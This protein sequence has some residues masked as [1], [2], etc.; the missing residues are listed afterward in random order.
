M[1]QKEKGADAKEEEDA[2]EG[3]HAALLCSEVVTTKQVA[4]CGISPEPIDAP[5]NYC[6]LDL[7]LLLQL[8]LGH[9][10]VNV[11]RA[12]QRWPPRPQ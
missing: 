9:N 10:E 5:S 6:G 3:A 8:G 4:G 12:A 7:A 1:L 11:L 2:C